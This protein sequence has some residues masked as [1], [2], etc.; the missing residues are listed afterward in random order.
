VQFRFVDTTEQLTQ[1][2]GRQYRAV[3]VPRVRIKSGKARN[4]FNPK[5]Y[6]KDNAELEEKL[7]RICPQYPAELLSYLLCAGQESFEFEPIF[8][9]RI[10][11]SSAWVQEP[12]FKYCPRCDKRM[13]LILQVP[14]SLIHPKRFH[15]GTFFQ[16]GC[17]AHPDQTASL[18]QFT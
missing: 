17:K 8:Q 3:A 6:L 2:L 11:T 16:F 4:R 14:G 5:Q 15:S 13:A 18:G 10:G 7:A 9:A 12:E 1:L